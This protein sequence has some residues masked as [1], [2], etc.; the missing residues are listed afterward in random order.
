MKSYKLQ[1]VAPLRFRNDDERFKEI[2]AVDMRSRS[3][4]ISFIQV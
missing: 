4:I 1:W 2:L 3:G